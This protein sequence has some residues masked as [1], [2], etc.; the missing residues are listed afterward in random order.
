MQTGELTKAWYTFI[1]TGAE[2]LKKDWFTFIQTG[3]VV[4]FFSGR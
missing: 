4:K 1:E 3:M 2:G